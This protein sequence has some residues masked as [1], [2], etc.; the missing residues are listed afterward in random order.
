MNTTQ[1]ID[2]LRI[3]PFPKVAARVGYSRKVIRNLLAADVAAG[4]PGERFPLPLKDR[5]N[6]RMEWREKSLMEW[7]ESRETHV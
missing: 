1:T 4:T 3:L 5:G 6:G 7:L 2:P